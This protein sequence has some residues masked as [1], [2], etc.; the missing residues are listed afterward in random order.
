MSSRPRRLTMLELRVGRVP[1]I[2]LRG[3]ALSAPFACNAVEATTHCHD[4]ALLT[5]KV[6]EGRQGSGSGD[7]RWR[8]RSPRV[9]KILA[10]QSARQSELSSCFPF[11]SYVAASRESIPYQMGS[12]NQKGL[13]RSEALVYGRPSRGERVSCVHGYSQRSSSTLFRG[14]TLSARLSCASKWTDA[15]MEHKSTSSPP[16]QC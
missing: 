10:E 3:D 11:H 6:V 2:G 8:R 5:L 4:R 14:R 15:S 16:L 13:I 9:S 7:C 12:E 1:E